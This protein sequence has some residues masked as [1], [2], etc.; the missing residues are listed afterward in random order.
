MPKG[1]YARKGPPGRPRK[2]KSE[3]DQNDKTLPTCLGWCG[4]RRFKPLFKFDRYCIKCR[5]IK[6]DKEKELSKRQANAIAVGSSSDDSY[7]SPVEGI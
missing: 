6:R 2:K 4:G 5:S 3:A 7:Y 1:V